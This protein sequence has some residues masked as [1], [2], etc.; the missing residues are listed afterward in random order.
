MLVFSAS[1]LLPGDVG[2]NVLGGFASQSDVAAAVIVTVAATVTQI[3]T[4][5]ITLS[6]SMNA[7]SR[8]RASA[9]C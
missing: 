1:S 7:Q 6:R 5:I 2:R 8:S 3:I 9:L 4:Q